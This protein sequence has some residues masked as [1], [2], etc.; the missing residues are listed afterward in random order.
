MKESFA[1]RVLA[2][3]REAGGD[4]ES[5]KLLRAMDIGYGDSPEKKRFYTALRDLRRSGKLVKVSPGVYRAIK[6]MG[7]PAPFSIAQVMWRVLRA[8]RSVTVEDLVEMA[9]AKASYAKEWLG[10][11]EGHG[12]IAAAGERYRLIKD[13]VEM[14]RD[15]AK[16]ERLRAMRA[17]K[18]E[19]WEKMRHAL[20]ELHTDMCEFDQ[21]ETELETDG[22]GG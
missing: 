20:L 10:M 2:R 19:L 22:E 14:P 1:G 15:E 8:K 6:P 13:T 21:F 11:L 5:V 3:I 12:V 18:K 7:A 17:R 4:V 16:A 9:G